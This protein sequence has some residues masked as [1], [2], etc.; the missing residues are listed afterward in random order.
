MN[1]FKITP[2]F[3]HWSEKQ[4]KELLSFI[5]ESKGLDYYFNGFGAQSYCPRLYYALENEIEAFNKAKYNLENKID[6]LLGSL[7]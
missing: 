7:I 1:D 4:K 2:K 6:K 5:Y 3:K